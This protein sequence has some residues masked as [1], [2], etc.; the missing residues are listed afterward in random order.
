MLLCLGGD[1][2]ASGGHTGQHVTASPRAQRPGVRAAG[3]GGER[4]AAGGPREVAVSDESRLT[5]DDD[6]KSAARV[7]WR[8]RS[9]TRTTR[10]GAFNCMCHLH[11]A[12]RKSSFFLPLL[13]GQRRVPVAEQR[14]HGFSST[15]SPNQPNCR[16]SMYPGRLSGCAER[17]RVQETTKPRGC[18]HPLNEAVGHVAVEALDLAYAAA[19]VAAL[20]SPQ[21]A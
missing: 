3:S 10:L 9:R 6:I 8:P 19:L 16:T 17:Q 2:A 11:A 7:S 1:K 20:R 21:E 4:P 13:R 12:L 15:T 5:T 18:S 14:P